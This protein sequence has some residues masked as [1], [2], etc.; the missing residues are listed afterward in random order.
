MEPN[1]ERVAL[2]L[3]ES[4]RQVNIE[5]ALHAQ[6]FGPDAPV[7]TVVGGVID[8]LPSQTALQGSERPMP[9][10]AGVGRTRHERHHQ[11]PSRV[12]TMHGILLGSVVDLRSAA[13]SRSPHTL[14]SLR[15]K[16]CEGI[17]EIG[18]L[19]ASERLNH[20]ECTG[21]VSRAAFAHQHGRR[22]SAGQGRLAPWR[23]VAWRFGANAK[24]QAAERPVAK[25]RRF[26]GRRRSPVSD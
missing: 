10:D 7:A 2:F 17:M 14:V 22:L 8:H 9:Q 1:E 20:S 25:R 3:I 24:P 12:A 15:P 18:R 6:G 23:R 5:V 21:N 26:R 13:A 19:P 11:Q 4:R 16:P